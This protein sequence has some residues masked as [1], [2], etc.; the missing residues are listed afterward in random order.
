[1]GVDHSSLDRAIDAIRSAYGDESVRF[2]DEKPLVARIPT[3]SIELDWAT[4]GGIPIGRW[5]HFY[6]GYMSSKTLTS[7]NVIREAQ[8]KGMTCAYYNIEKQYDPKWVKNHGIKQ[9]E[10]V[11]VEGTEIERIGAKMEAL[12][13]SVDLHVVDSIASAVSLEELAARMEDQSM[14]LAARTWG[15]VIRKLLDRFDDAQ[16]CVV[17]INQVRDVFGRGGGEAPP[18]GK[19]ID[20]TSSLNLHFRRSHWLNR[21]P[22]GVL[23]PEAKAAPSL[24]G[25]PQPAGIEFQVRVVKSR[26]GPPLRT[27]RMRMDFETGK[28]DETW[29]LVKGAKHFGVVEVKGGWYRLADGTKHHGESKFREALDSDKKLRKLVV[30]VMMAQ[31]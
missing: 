17:M 18:G 30:D 29:A 6:G 8:A 1:M 20:F 12:L 16:N 19:M 10:L 7:W 15:R 25:D 26:V 21:R 4:A 23:D 31:M 9:N 14:G 28:F 13:P 11:V 5:S 24:T 27:A 22:D 3:G 2:G